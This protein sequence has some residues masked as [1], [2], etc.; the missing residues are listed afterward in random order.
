MAKKFQQQYFAFRNGYQCGRC[1]KTGLL[2]EGQPH[3]DGVGAECEPPN[4]VASGGDHAENIP[5]AP[6]ATKVDGQTINVLIDDGLAHLKPIT[7]DEH[8]DVLS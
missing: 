8:G 6:A 7:L 3:F 4:T 2:Y 5:D 1:M